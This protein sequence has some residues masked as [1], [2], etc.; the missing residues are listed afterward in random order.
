MDANAAV[1]Y[2]TFEDGVRQM[3]VLDAV[4]ESSQKK[5]WVTVRD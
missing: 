2:P 5:A 1:D 3:R 4:L